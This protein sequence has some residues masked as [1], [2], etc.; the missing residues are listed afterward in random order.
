MAS[1]Q[2]TESLPYPPARVW[3][4]LTEPAELA[5]WWAPG[6]IRPVLGHRFTIDMG[7]RGLQ[8]CEVLA[9]QTL[10]LLSYSFA[11]RTL[12]T[13]VTWT[14]QTDSLGTRLSLEHAG[15]DLSSPLARQ[16]YQGMS[17]G[18][19]RVMERLQQ[20]LAAHPA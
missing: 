8:P 13:A 18:W 10:R 1:V 7:S 3:R 9:V 15:F 19:P 6:D 4:A 14:L 16:A 11:P 2:I 20:M 12:H 5:Q 17:A